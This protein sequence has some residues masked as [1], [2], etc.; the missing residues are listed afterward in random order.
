MA[1]LIP[2]LG[3]CVARMTSG[4][5]RW[6]ERLQDKLGA[7]SVDTSLAGFE[8]GG[9]ESGAGAARDAT[10]FA[11]ATKSPPKSGGTSLAGFAFGG[12]FPSVPRSTHEYS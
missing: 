1:T 6:A 4:E 8:S 9:V 10:A 12:R 3:T 2:A 7:E 11:A 5:R